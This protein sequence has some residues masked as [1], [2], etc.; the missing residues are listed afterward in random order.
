ML[1]L[2]WT[3]SVLIVTVN[4][5]LLS[6]YKS[7]SAYQMSDVQI[8]P[9]VRDFQLHSFYNNLNWTCSCSSLV[10]YGN[11]VTWN[12][13][14]VILIKRRNKMA[15]MFGNHCYNY[16]YN[17]PF[18]NRII[19]NTNFKTFDIPMCLVFQY[20]RY[21]IS[22]CNSYFIIQIMGVFHN[23]IFI[24]LFCRSSQPFSIVTRRKSSIGIWKPRTFCWTAKWTSRSPTSASA[25]SSFRE[26][27]STHSVE[28]HLMRR[29]NYFKVRIV[30]TLI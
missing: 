5:R 26:T 23:F 3:Y 9:V 24:P 10:S 27:S 4:I 14:S 2:S 13:K 1:L 17:R 18:Q 6:C 30:D 22:H 25:T 29:Q 16:G 11:P 12:R 21:S 15:R 7:L 20:N 19:G 28:V 8:Q